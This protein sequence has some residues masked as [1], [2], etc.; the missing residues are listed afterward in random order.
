MQPAQKIGQFIADMKVPLIGNVFR[1]NTNEPKD[2][3]DMVITKIR[4]LLPNVTIEVEP[5]PVGD[6]IFRSMVFERKSLDFANFPLVRQQCVEMLANF[7]EVYVLVDTDLDDVIHH[8]Y[9]NNPTKAVS[10]NGFVASLMVMGVTPLF[11]S[12]PE[13][14]A[15]I[16]VKICLKGMDHKDRLFVEP[17][18]PQASDSDEI[19]HIVKSISGVSTERG[20]ALLMK[21]KTV[22][23]IASA[24]IEDLTSV[25]G[26]GPKTA[27]SI[28]DAFRK[29]WGE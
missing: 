19:L 11:C 28:Y 27:R 21:F 26:V 4:E 2:M 15:E 18:R 23:G 25:E 8:L 24:N 12:D 3:Q 22:S 9:E 10:L 16:M 29:E 17:I 7:K 14:F 20:R 13:Y 5:F 1:I 6:Y